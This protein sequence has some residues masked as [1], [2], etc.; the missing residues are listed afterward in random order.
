M[1]F[2]PTD[3]KKEV[4]NRKQSSEEIVSWTPADHPHY[5]KRLLESKKQGNNSG[6]L[7]PKRP[8]TPPKENSFNFFV[9]CALED[10]KVDSLDFDTYQSDE[11]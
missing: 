1:F 2:G 11:E 10:A 6:I 7:Q 5:K 3:K 8:P 4:K 9:C